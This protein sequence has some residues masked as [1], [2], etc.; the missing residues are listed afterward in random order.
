MMSIHNG[1]LME[2]LERIAKAL[3]AVMDGKNDHIDALT[4]ENKR[5]R[6]LLDECLDNIKR[7]F[8]IDATNNIDAALIQQ[9]E[10]ALT[11]QQPTHAPDRATKRHQYLWQTQT[12]E[13]P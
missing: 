5:L 7:R 12:E 10:Q 1:D 13:Q 6:F 2:K 9:C 8:G 4:A 3:E 11:D